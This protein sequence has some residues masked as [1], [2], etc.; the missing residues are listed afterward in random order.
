[1]KQGKIISK[2]KKAKNRCVH[3]ISPQRRK[4]SGCFLSLWGLSDAQAQASQDGI[5]SPDHRLKREKDHCIT[6][7]LQHYNLI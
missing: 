3:A 2:Y 1:M 6:F 7:M 4:M 5:F